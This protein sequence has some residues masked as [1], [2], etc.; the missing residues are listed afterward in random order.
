[1]PLGPIPGH[2]QGMWGYDCDEALECGKV[3]S[4]S[5]TTT[6]TTTT[7]TSPVPSVRRGP[8][9]RA[10][11]SSPPNLLFN[12]DVPNHNVSPTSETSACQDIFGAG[13]DR[14]TGARPKDART[15]A[16]FLEQPP[17]WFTSYMTSVGLFQ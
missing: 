17:D 4:T 14:G 6:T 9:V 12:F 16:D 10:L 8:P 11:R 3:N 2:V 5:T 7:T 1:M 13:V 15:K